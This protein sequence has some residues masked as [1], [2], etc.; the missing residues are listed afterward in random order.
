MPQRFLKPGLTTSKKW[1][2]VDW[3]AQSFYVRLITLVDDFGRYEG[4]LLLLRSH[5]FPYGDPNRNEIPLTTIENICKQLTTNAL[6]I[7]YETHDGMRYLQLLRWQE[8]PRAISSKYPAFDNTCKQMFSNVSKCSPPSSSSSSSPSSPPIVPQR[9]TGGSPQITETQLR[10]ARLFHRRE[11]TPWSEKE[12]KAFRAIG[13][14]QNEDLEL[15]ERYYAMQFPKDKDYRRRDLCTL[16]NNFQGELDRARKYNGN[17]SSTMSLE[18]KIAREQLSLSE[19][20]IGG[21]Q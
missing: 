1:N 15:L 20:L 5:C 21:A 7:F 18:R 10:L 9:G 8:R 13:E 2:A 4:D 3:I 12:R 11:T 17:T 6:I 16:L 19:R 14:I